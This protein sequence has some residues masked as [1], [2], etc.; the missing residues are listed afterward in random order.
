MSSCMHMRLLGCAVMVN[1]SPT[2]QLCFP[3]GGFMS[4][5]HLTQYTGFFDTVELLFLAENVGNVTW[6]VPGTNRT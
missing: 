1:K 3:R 2:L 6:Q 4:G 5:L